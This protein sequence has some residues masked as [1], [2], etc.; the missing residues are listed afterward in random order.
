MRDPYEV[1]GVAK[2]ADIKDV[3]KAYRKL[4]RDLHPDLHPGDRKAEDR[5]KEVASAYDFLSDVEKKARYDRGEI[6]ASGM[7]RAE[8]TF[9]RDYAES[10]SG[11]RY[12][13]PRE[14]FRD[15]EGMD[16]FADLFGGRAGARGGAPRMA[17]G[18]VRHVVEIDFLDGVNGA[19]RSV[20]MSDGK[21]LR[22]T[23]PAGSSD[24]DVLRLKGQGSAG[25]GGGPAGD[26]LIELKVRPHPSF[27]RKGRD[28]YA[29][30]PV[31]LSEAVLG[32]KVEAQT[33]DGPVS[34][35][36]PKGSNTGSRLRVRGKG[37]PQPGGGRGDHY[38]ELKVVLPAQP[39]AELTRLVEEW[40]AKH[41]YTVR[42]R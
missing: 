41:P 25:L 40:S 2:G 18:D 13:D 9:Y 16:I 1:L 37:V 11:A 30:L 23:I 20:V 12:A 39:D 15:M 34:L 35:T 19:T 28:I 26:L 32:G 42:G 10:S 5:F 21:H 14:Y 4:A 17:G 27:T 36:V 6:D 7:P 8:R 24:G 22:V 29:E 3:K 38:V 31:T 33:V